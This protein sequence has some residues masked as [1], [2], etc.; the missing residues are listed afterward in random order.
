[1]S[2]AATYFKHLSRQPSCFPLF[3]SYGQNTNCINVAMV[4]SAGS[5]L[6]ISEKK[7]FM[8]YSVLMASDKGDE[9]SSYESVV[10]RCACLGP[11]SGAA[12]QVENHRSGP[13]MLLVQS[14]MTSVKPVAPSRVRATDAGRTSGAIASIDFP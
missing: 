2:S 14:R 6:M 7:T 13:A 12:L 4:G 3:A 11:R 1:M 9:I 10:R 5:F 8:D